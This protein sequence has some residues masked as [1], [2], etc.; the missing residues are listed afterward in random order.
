[1][2]YDVNNSILKSNLHI[3]PKSPVGDE[4]YFFHILAP[5]SFSSQ[6]PVPYREPRHVC[7]VQIHVC[8]CRSKALSALLS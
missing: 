6:Q 7:D 1:M 3:M 8:A 4:Y 2:R 5:F